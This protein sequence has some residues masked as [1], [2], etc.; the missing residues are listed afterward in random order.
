MGTAARTIVGR[1][2]ERRRLDELV[3]RARNGEGGVLVLRGEAG[4]GKSVLLDHVRGAA[5]GMRVVEASGAE[6]E[7]E[8]PFAGLHQLC[9]PLLSDVD[10]P[11]PLRTALDAAFG[12]AEGTPEIFRVGMAALEL[13]TSAADAH[14]LLCLVDDAHWLDDASLRVL[15]FLARRVAAEPVVMV[16]AAR[17]GLD[18]LPGVELTGLTDDDAHRL[19]A[20]TRT[21]LDQAVRDR[22]LAEAG[23]N[24][25]ALLELPGAGGFAMPA[26]SSVASRVERSFSDRLAGLPPDVRLLLTVASADPTG[27][28]GLLW[29]AA[30]LLGVKAYAGAHAEASGLVVLGPGVRF[31]H[32]LARSA[33]YRAAAVDDRH[34]VHAA[35]AGVT[36]PVRDHD[37]RAWHRAMA[38][39]GPDE[40]VA[41]ELD[42]SA[43]RALA[44]GG[45]AAAAAFHERAAALSRDQ[46]RRVERTLA[47]AHAHLDAGAPDEAARL[48]TTV[49]S[50]DD[51]TVA[52]VELMR[53]RIA[54]VRH[55]D[56]DGPAFM[57]SAARR[58]A[59]TDPRR[60]RDCYLDAVEMALVVGRASGVMDMV[61]E[62]A[63]SA[64]AVPGPP[65]LLD[66]LVRLAAEG[67][68]A[69]SRPVREAVAASP[70][71][72]ERPALAGMLAVELWD[73]GTHGVITDWVLARARETGSPLM[74]RLGLGMAAASAVHV[75]DFSAATS[76]IAEEEAVADAI[77]V[78]PLGYPR[79]HLA[80]M[81]GRAAEARTMIGTFTA[82][83]AASG[84]GQTIANA[85]W[86]AA[87]LANGL[88]NYP[89]AL[90]A[91]RE[92]TRHGDLF[93]TAIALPEL[94]EAA[95]RSGDH[96]TAEAAL[97]SLTERTE[98]SGTPWALGVGAYARALVT[99][100]EADH[101]AALDHLEAT[102]LAPYL[103][104]AHLLYG[105]WLRRQ[106]RRRDART[107][108][109]AARE[110]LSDIGMT[111]FADRATAELRAAGEDVRGR[112]TGDTD[113][114]TAQET[115]IARLVAGGATSKEV[116]GRLFISPRTVDAHL[117]N[118][119][120]KLGITSRRQLRELPTLR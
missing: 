113:D 95:A 96:E 39:S 92:A 114:L 81:R 29:A 24:P 82:E 9:A 16:L 8:F 20:D 89:A 58:L 32:P 94:V 28:P 66:A 14:P 50:D 111:A 108:L 1:D 35:L 115:H 63:R 44:R 71:W 55:R 41:A 37:R 6:F 3:G 101:R 78:A 18:D 77:G 90:T 85:H 36:D 100:D 83:A 43:A 59:A 87:V 45:V 53:G 13:L 104:R 46:D 5:R 25:L 19:L 4:I 48:L 38:G 106:G 68:R 105:E 47:A 75:G 84:T 15:T 86:A 76:A 73:V 30:E 74:L 57:L 40:D 34:A 118:I 2:T 61:V 60:S 54:F 107:Q 110:R 56:G 91:A 11:E 52:R 70:L 33:V 67:H 93:V 98:G 117:R 10:L 79:L 88:A 49:A 64:P 99:G 116:A 17:H 102:S 72:T 65:D 112:T 21:T 22:V 120:R 51:A 62:A 103:A 69:A 27:D 12:L 42:R 23:G 119:F 109:R 26:T 80:A 7:T 97:T 31:C